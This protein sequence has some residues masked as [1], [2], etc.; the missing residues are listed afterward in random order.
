[1]QFD[2]VHVCCSTERIDLDGI[3]NSLFVEELEK[4]HYFLMKIGVV[5]GLIMIA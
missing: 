5:I 2:K 1:M 4:R 3:N